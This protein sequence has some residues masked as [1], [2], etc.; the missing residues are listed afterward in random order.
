MNQLLEKSRL[1]NLLGSSIDIHQTPYEI[2]GL[3]PDVK[4]NMKV[5]SGIIQ[6]FHGCSSNAN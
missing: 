6:N 3:I 1:M 2:I 5:T 4:L